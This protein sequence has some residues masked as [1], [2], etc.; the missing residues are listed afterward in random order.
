MGCDRCSNTYTNS[1][2]ELCWRCRQT[3]YTYT[4]FNANANAF[5]NTNSITDTH[6]YVTTTGNA[7]AFT[8]SGSNNYSNTATKEGTG[9]WSG[10]RNCRAVSSGVYSFEEEDELVEI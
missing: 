2:T 4:K 1:K 6:A 10:V 7:N 9:I 3:N 8:N 5:T